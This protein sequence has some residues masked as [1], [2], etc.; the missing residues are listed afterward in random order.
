MGLPCD[1]SC[2]MRGGCMRCEPLPTALE[3]EVQELRRQV[4]RL[5]K[6]KKRKS[7]RPQPNSTVRKR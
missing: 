7:C 5:T 3:L 6:K 2:Y 1:Y 4:A